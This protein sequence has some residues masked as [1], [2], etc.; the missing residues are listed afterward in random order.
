MYSTRY[1]CQGLKKIEF[2]GQIFAQRLTCQIKRK[3]AQWEPRCST[4]ALRHD[5]ANNR[6][7]QFCERAYKRLL[8]VTDHIV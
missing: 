4:R 3:L 8:K 6:F 1:S 2:S 5:K 7:S